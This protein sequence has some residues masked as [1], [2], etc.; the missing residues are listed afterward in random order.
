MKYTMFPWAYGRGHAAFWMV[1]YAPNVQ[2]VV[3]V[4]HTCKYALGGVHRL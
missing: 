2:H 1:D 4:F 3:Q